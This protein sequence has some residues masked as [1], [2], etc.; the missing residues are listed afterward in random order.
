M[1][2]S[3]INAIPLKQYFT[4]FSFLKSY[5]NVSS[6]SLV[7]CFLHTTPKNS[8]MQSAGTELPLRADLARSVFNGLLHVL[9]QYPLSLSILH[10]IT[11]TQISALTHACTS[12]AGAVLTIP[13][14]KQEPPKQQHVTATTACTL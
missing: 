11:L 9:H 8:V 2:I 4:P 13:S 7:W 5:L 1:I 12:R 14:D 3:T 10:I 6:K